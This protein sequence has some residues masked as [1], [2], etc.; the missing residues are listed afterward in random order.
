MRTARVRNTVDTS[1]QRTA[2]VGGVDAFFGHRNY[3]VDGKNSTHQVK[4]EFLH[5]VVGANTFSVAFLVQQLSC[6]TI[7]AAVVAGALQHDGEHGRRR[8]KI[9]VLSH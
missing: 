3:E 5:S 2:L 4:A 7:V 1:E 6:D 8:M 9:P